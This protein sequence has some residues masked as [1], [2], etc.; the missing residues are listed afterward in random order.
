MDNLR[1]LR[2]R[3]HIQ[4]TRYDFEPDEAQAFNEERKVL[5]EK[6][7]EKTLKTMTEKYP[8]DERYSYVDGF[9]LPWTEHYHS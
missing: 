9:L 8:R 4:N 2:N 1:K 7:L 3:I 6:V 5:A